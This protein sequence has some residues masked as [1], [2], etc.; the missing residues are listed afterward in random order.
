MKNNKLSHD[1]HEKIRNLL[2]D[3]FSKIIKEES[4]VPV[5]TSF[6]TISEILKKD[7]AWSYT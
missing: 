6:C 3:N 2:K 7:S 1:D 5:E 4:R